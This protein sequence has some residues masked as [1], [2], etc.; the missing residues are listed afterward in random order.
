M[1]PVAVT[2]K[3]Q[4]FSWDTVHAPRATSGPPWPVNS[5]YFI[6]GSW[7]YP[8]LPGMPP[9]DGNRVRRGYGPHHWTGCCY[10]ANVVPAMCHFKLIT[11]H[12][13]FKNLAPRSQF[14]KRYLSPGE[15]AGMKLLP[16]YGIN[17]N[18]P[19]IGHL[20]GLLEELANNTAAVLMGTQAQIESLTAEMVA[21]RIV[22]LQN[23]MALEFILAEKGGTRAIKGQDCCSYIPNESSNI[24]D[25]ADHIKK[26]PG[27]GG[28]T[29]WESKPGYMELVYWRVCLGAC[30]AL[31]N[32]YYDNYNHHFTAL[33]LCT[34]YLQIYG[35]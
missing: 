30:V 33:F 7:A 29:G 19:R 4:G 14:T 32:Y 9:N 18:A 6:C 23:Q 21:M 12:P 2:I 3:A 5:T 1:P 35:F 10:L 17:W 28:E 24:T 34:M 8:W 13:I 31:W 27:W 25:P 22:V 16:W 11:D 26:D 15:S 20:T